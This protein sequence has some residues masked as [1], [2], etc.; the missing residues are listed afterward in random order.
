MQRDIQGRTYLDFR[1]ILEVHHGTKW[2]SRTERGREE[3]DDRKGSQISELQED[4]LQ[5][6]S[7]HG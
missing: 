1:T 5:S 4:S 3:G 2:S 7:I 6:Q